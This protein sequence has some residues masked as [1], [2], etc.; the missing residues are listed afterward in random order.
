MED[1]K[2]EAMIIGAGVRGMD[3][4]GK[5]AKDGVADMKVVS[6]V[7]I[8]DEKLVKME[9][10]HDI[11]LHRC[12]HSWEQALSDPKFCDAVI[13]S[14]PDET[15]R[16]ISVA[17][18]RQGYNV[19]LEKPMATSP[20][21]CADIFLE[22]K[23]SGKIMSIA[24]VLR[25]APFFQEI[26]EKIDS[27]EFG[28]I[29]SLDMLE[30]VGYWHFPHSYVRGNWR[31]KDESGPVIL[32]K[33]CH[34]MDI[35]NWLVNNTPESV[36]STGSLN[37][38]TEKNAPE[39]STD[40]CVDDCKVKKTCPYNAERIYLDEKDPEKVRWPALVISPNDTTIEA[41]KKTLE[42]GPY[43]RCVYRCDND[44]CDNQEVNIQF[45]NGV[46]VRFGLSPFGQQPTRK[47]NLYLENGEIHGDL[48][49]GKMSI[50][51]YTGMGWHDEPEEIDV[52]GKGKGG[53]GG[54]DL[55]LVRDFITA[56]KNKDEAANLTSAEKSLDG[57]LL[58]FAAEESRLSGKEINFDD[59]KARYY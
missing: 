41:R 37:H 2:L 26:K 24:H 59:Y 45:E 15:H 54:G 6:V 48:F 55:L 14:T 18:L 31:R 13:I 1:G 30:E 42:E 19:L 40:R 8:D 3:K 22:Q 50:L 44:V 23:T 34:D 57:T 56:V 7:D 47:L 33:S 58:S 20:K 53:H 27:G 12:Y 4:Y 5:F 46:N 52:S 28:K 35:I 51:K 39:G 43:G 21:E 16:D 38:F 36:F 11:P 17:A 29:R 10:E 49:S 32:T 25:Y 9:L